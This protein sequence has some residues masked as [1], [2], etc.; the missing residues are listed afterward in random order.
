MKLI[1]RYLD[2]WTTESNCLDERYLNNLSKSEQNHKMYSL[3][4]HI[5]KYMTGCVQGVTRDS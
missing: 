5:S 3:A 2:F 1:L 4:D